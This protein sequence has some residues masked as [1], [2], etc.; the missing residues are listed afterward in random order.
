[1]AAVKLSHLISKHNP[2]LAAYEVEHEEPPVL[3]L[4][5][6]NFRIAFS[7]EDVYGPYTLRDDPDYVKWIFR[8][9]VKKEGVMS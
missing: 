1:M 7:L 4:V 5:Q 9:F 3:D 2:N 6:N 8:M